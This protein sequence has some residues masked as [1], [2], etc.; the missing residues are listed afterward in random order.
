MFECAR[1]DELEQ[2]RDILDS[3]SSFA[4]LRNEGPFGN[5]RNVLHVA[6]A[7]GSETVVRYILEHLTWSKVDLDAVD[8]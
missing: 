7:R 6:C 4:S 1:R 2:I 3:A 8:D 5:G